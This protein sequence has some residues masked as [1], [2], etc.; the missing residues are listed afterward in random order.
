MNDYESTKAVERY[1]HAWFEGL[2][3]YAFTI[4]GDNDDAKDAVQAV[5]LKLLEK[6]ALIND[7]LSV[8]TYLYVSVYN[9]CL[10]V[11]RHRKVKAQY[12]AWSA[13]LP[14]VTDDP[15]ARKETSRQIMDAVESLPPRCRQVFMKS[16]FEKKKY[17]EIAQELDISV[18][19]VEV[20]MGKALKILR[21]ELF[22]ALALIM[23]LWLFYKV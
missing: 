4:L 19:T 16:R 15:L 10:N 23:I 8:K 20:Q 9:H 6:K 11:H 22:G 17:A 13:S 2:H 12:A 1:F 14:P 3:R 7:R 5:F 18:K 21:R